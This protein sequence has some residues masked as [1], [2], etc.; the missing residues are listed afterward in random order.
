MGWG[1]VGGRGGGAASSNSSI[2]RFHNRN[3][4]IS[5][6]LL[7]APANKNRNMY[8]FE[9]IRKLQTNIQFLKLE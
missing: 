2:G 3:F 9:T 6:L 8:F 7:L 1:G 4:E 5:P